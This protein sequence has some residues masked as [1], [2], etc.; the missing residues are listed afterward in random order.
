[1]N[2]KAKKTSRHDSDSSSDTDSSESNT[3][4]GIQ[5][6]GNCKL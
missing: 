2:A 4:Q 6:I 5:G 3:P 1:M